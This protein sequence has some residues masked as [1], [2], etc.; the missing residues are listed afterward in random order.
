[1]SEENFEKHPQLS[2]E[3]NREMERILRENAP[4]LFKI[5][6]SDIKTGEHRV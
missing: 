5:E 4:E 1:L 6:H 3:N 2:N